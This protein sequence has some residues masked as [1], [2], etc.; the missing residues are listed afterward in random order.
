MW[1]GAIIMSITMKDVR[2]QLEP[3][4]PDYAKAAQ[5]G[6]NAIPYLKELV[7]GE[8]IMLASKA[9]YLASLIKNENSISILENAARNSQP[10]VRVAVA[11]GLRNLS[12]ENADRVSNLLIED[13]D[14]GVRKVTVK[15][16]SQFRSPAL[17]AKVRKLA[18]EDPES[19]LRD[20]ASRTI[21][22]IR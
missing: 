17:I 6:P 2:T 8:D 1:R 3:D 19:F 10:V 18:R 22:D 20:L 7:N 16:I 15:S 12:E 21:E 14:V 9:A 5:L 4:E 11:S 13:R